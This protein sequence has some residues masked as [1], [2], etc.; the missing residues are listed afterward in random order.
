[1]NT[2]DSCT[3]VGPTIENIT[4]LCDFC[5]ELTRLIVQVSSERNRLDGLGSYKF[6]GQR[7]RLE[8][9]VPGRGL[10]SC[11]LCGILSAI[12]PTTPA[13]SKT[14]LVRN[15]INSQS[16]VLERGMRVCGTSIG[17]MGFTMWADTGKKLGVYY[18]WLR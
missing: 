1:M 8:E 3:T 15:R 11:Q 18:L 16:V 13:D 17:G 6:Y 9:L 5:I 10:E 4:D 12:L 7:G 2:Q 14:S